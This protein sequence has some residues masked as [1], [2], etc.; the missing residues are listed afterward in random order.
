[1]ITIEDILNQLNSKISEEDRRLIR[2]AY[3]F[4]AKAH[5]DQKRASGEPYIVHPIGVVRTLAAMNLDAVTIAA[6]FLHDV[7]DDTPCTVKDIE[8][9]FGPEIAFLVSGVTK[10][11]KLKY[12]GVER[13][14]ENLRKMFLAMA[15]D[16][17][18][19][20]IKLADRLHNMESL[21]FLPERKQKRIAL[22]TMEIYAPLADRLGIFKMRG[23]L[24]D[25]AF[26]YI[27][28][29]EYQG[30]IKNVKE[31]YKEREVYLKRIQPVVEK[32]LKEEGVEPIEMH[33]RA[34]H[35]YSLWK[36]LLKYEMDL[37]KIHDLVALRII[38]PS[39]EKCYLALGIIHKYWKPL[40]GKIKD[41]I[42]LPKPNGYQSLHTTI[43]CLEGKL[44]EIQI[45]TPELHER[46]EYGIAAHWAYAD[47]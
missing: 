4:A 21:S 3:E 29:Q 40:P 41:Y 27:Y 35:Y 46:A 34:K 13:Q 14:V 15:Q 37:E 9:E 36:K 10:L 20:L 22:E 12:R 47:T 33:S 45:R 28:P 5:Q 31:K 30:L 43:F 11:G 19:V 16:I 18:V 2:R 32:K 7:A 38:V 17:R 25:L 44:T 8:N 23:D 39:V 6:G 24:E 42:A 1:M 26:P